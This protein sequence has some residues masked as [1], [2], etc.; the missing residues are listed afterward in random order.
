MKRTTILGITVAIVI[1]ISIVILIWLLFSASCISDTYRKRML[2]YYADDNVYVQ[3]TGEVIEKDT[4][5]SAILKIKI[6]LFDSDFNLYGQDSDYF[7]LYSN[8]EILDSVYIGDII[9][10]TSAPRIF[11]DGQKFPILSLSKDGQ[12]LLSFEEGK[13]NYLKWIKEDFR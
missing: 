6:T 1:A 11:Y 10:F 4:Y 12:E 5:S 2:E 7:M 8:I 9:E 13:S 3:L